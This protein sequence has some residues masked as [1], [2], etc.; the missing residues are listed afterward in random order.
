MNKQTRPVRTLTDVI[1]MLCYQDVTLA[2]PSMRSTRY[3]LREREREITQSTKRQD[4][5]PTETLTG[6]VEI[7]NRE[8]EPTKP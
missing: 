3:V 7:H 4:T 8:N 6:K 5:Q 1:S 2:A